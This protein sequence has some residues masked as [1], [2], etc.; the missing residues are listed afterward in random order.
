MTKLTAFDE[1]GTGIF[2]S[3]DVRIPQVPSGSPIDDDFVS[4]GNGRGAL[5]QTYSSGYS[6]RM[7]ILATSDTTYLMEDLRLMQDFEVLIEMT[8]INIER[9]TIFVDTNPVN[10]FTKADQIKGTNFA[11]FILSGSGADR[12]NGKGGGDILSGEAGSDSLFGQAGDDMISGA[13]GNDLLRGDAGA[14]RLVGGVGQDTM[15]GGR[16]GAADVFVLADSKDS[17]VDAAD[18]ILNFRANDKISLELLSDET[19]QLLFTEKASAY[20]VWVQSAPKLGGFHVRVDI[21]GDAKADMR[22]V[23]VGETI[24][25]ADDFLL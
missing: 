3:G 13:K 24:L 12:V 6:S 1:I 14:D 23:V 19:V 18:T 22:L 8:D 2:V 25:T 5:T 20:G 15:D 21:T 9:S 11:D 7:V 4:F 17:L 10:L 16:D